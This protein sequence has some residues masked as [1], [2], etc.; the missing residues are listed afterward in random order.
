M[1]LRSMATAIASRT[2][3]SLMVSVLKSRTSVQPISAEAVRRA[4]LAVSSF[5]ASDAWRPPALS[6]VRAVASESASSCWLMVDWAVE[7]LK[8]KVSGSAVRF[9]SVAGS[10]AGLRT[11]CMER[12][13]S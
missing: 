5:A 12:P 3:G 11:S 4:T 9:G 13:R 7:R 8:V 6:S 2:T 1:A 10:H